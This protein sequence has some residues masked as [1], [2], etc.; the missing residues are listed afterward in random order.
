[1]EQLTKNNILYSQNN[2]CSEIPT[3]PQLSVRQSCLRIYTR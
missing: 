3:K 1:M 2:K